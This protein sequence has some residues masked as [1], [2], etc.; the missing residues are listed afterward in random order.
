VAFSFC[1]EKCLDYVINDFCDFWCGDVLGFLVY[2]ADFGWF[3]FED[4]SVADGF[5][6]PKAFA[7]CG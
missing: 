5:D 2:Y 4:E 3:F 7:Y 1:C 6:I